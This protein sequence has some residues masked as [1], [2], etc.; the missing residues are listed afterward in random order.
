[1]A[2]RSSRTACGTEAD[3]HFRVGLSL[4]AEELQ[5]QD[6]IL[7]DSPHGAMAITSTESCS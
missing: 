4:N 5:A 2:C 3:V 7:L 1:M 6:Y